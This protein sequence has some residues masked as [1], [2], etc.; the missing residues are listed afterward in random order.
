M[1]E[2][3]SI[4][5]HRIGDC[6][7]LTLAGDF[8]D[9][10]AGTL[11]EAFR[12]HPNKKMRIFVHTEGLESVQPSGCETLRNGLFYLPR[13]RLGDLLFTGPNAALIAPRGIRVLQ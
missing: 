13:K 5:R 12:H 3:F 11:V 10:S 6:L 1:R 9:R 4:D 2:D 8:D 7:H